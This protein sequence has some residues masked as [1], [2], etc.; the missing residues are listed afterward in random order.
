MAT[1]LDALDAA[2]NHHMAGRTDAAERNYRLILGVDPAQPDAL[3]LLGVLRAQTGQPDPAV[4][5]LTRSVRV[6]PGAPQPWAHLAGAL[7]TAERPDEAERVVRRALAL[8]PASADALDI[9]GATLHAL[10]RYPQA[11]DWLH[12]ANALRPG[13][14]ETLLNLGTV[15]R[16]QRRFDEADRVFDVALARHPSNAAIH[17]ARAVGRLVR[18]DLIGGWEGFEHRWR[19][20]PAPPW[21]GEPLN[22]A[23]ILLHMEQ[24]FGDAMQFVRY[25][26]LVARAGGRVVVEASPALFRLFQASLDPSIAVLVRGPEPPPHDHHCPLMSL[27]RAFGTDLGSVPAPIPYLMPERGD[28]NLWRDR[29][30]EGPEGLRVGLVW[31]G[32]PRHRNDRNRSLPVAALRP[33]VNVPGVRFI[34]LQVG[35]ARSALA[36]LA[37]DAAVEDPMDRVRDFADTAAI[38]ANIDLLIS[39][40]TAVVHLAGAM[41]VP[42]WLLLPHAPDWRWLL[43]RDDSP[44]YPSLRLFR[45]PRPGDWET[46]LGRVAATLRAHAH[47]PAD[48]A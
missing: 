21:A 31:A 9:L 24:G 48:P 22:G 8:D 45:Q 10:A 17:L 37:P 5:L 26:P 34:S 16:D 27:P 38:L 11:A 3:H 30:A 39:V 47:Q 35:E 46:T 4:A 20:L 12:R 42:V 25:A 44:W 43:N 28:R 7:R 18:G 19:R 15:L 1:L 6:R 23:T 41:G 36:T 13:H 32:N 40:D 29:L 2:V 14:P 33:L